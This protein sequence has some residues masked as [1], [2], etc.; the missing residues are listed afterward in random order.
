MWRTAYQHRGRNPFV[1]C[2]KTGDAMADRMK[3]EDQPDGSDRLSGSWRAVVAA[4][5]V[6]VLLVV[7]SAGAEALAARHITPPRHTDLAGAVIPRHDPACAEVPTGA[8]PGF[9]LIL[10]QMERNGYPLW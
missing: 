9:A 2:S 7:F 6:V 4:W 5:A 8:C 1:R 10:T 3:R